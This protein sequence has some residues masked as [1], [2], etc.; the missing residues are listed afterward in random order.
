MLMLDLG[1]IEEVLEKRR[2]R[3]A[4]ETGIK[5]KYYYKRKANIKTSTIKPMK[6]QVMATPTYSWWD[7]LL[8]SLRKAILG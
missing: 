4:E 6:A 7:N 1:Y 5:P 3:M 8:W 2:K